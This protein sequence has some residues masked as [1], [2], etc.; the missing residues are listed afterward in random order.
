MN[1]TAQSV[2]R[3][4]QRTNTHVCRQEAVS[5]DTVTVLAPRV[6]TAVV[7]VDVG[8]PSS[9]LRLLPATVDQG[10]LSGVTNLTEKFVSTRISQSLSR[11]PS[12][13]TGPSRTKLPI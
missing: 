9:L 1:V 5:P 2:L 6:L 4:I 11:A 13:T 3:R 7:D 12:T 10:N 8:L